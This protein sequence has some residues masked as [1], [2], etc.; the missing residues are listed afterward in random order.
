MK[1]ASSS[2][3]SFSLVSSANS[4][5]VFSPSSS[6]SRPMASLFLPISASWLEVLAF[7]C[8]TLISRRRVDM[9]NSARNWSLSAWISAI[10]SGVKASSRR[11]VRRTA[12]ACTSGMTPMTSKPATRN[13]I[14]TNMI[15]SIMGLR[16]LNP[17]TLFLPECHGFPPATS[18][19][20]G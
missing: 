19:P 5:A 11:C 6:L 2:L 4:A 15:G 3:S 12:R 17:S 10:E 8:S 20:A 14:P 1:S 13:P 16:L 18:V 9:A 7:I